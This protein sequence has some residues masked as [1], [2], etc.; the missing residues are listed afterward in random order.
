LKFIPLG[1]SEAMYLSLGGEIRQDM[2]YFDNAR[3]GQSPQSDPYS[4]QRYMLASDWHLGPRFRLYFQIKSGLE[5]G[6]KGGPRQMIDEDKLDVNNG[7]ADIQLLSKGDT[8]IVFRL[9][10]QELAFG[11]RRY[12]SARDGPNVRQTFDGFRLNLLTRG[13]DVSAFA[14]RPVSTDPGIFDDG[15]LQGHSFWGVYAAHPKLVLR[16]NIDI[17]YFGYQRNPATF[18]R[19]TAAESRQSLGARAWS[20]KRAWDYDIE[21]ILQFGTFGDSNILAWAT[22][23]EVGHTLSQTALTPRLAVRSSISSGDKPSKDSSLG[24]FNPLFPRGQYHQLVNLNGHVNLIDFDPLISINP[25]PKMTITTDCDVFWRE[26]LGDG[27]YTVGGSP[28]KASGNS[29][30]R[31]I[32]TQPNVIMV[33]P[34]QRHFTAVFI[35]SHFFS[36]AYLHQAPTFTT[37][38]GIV[39][40]YYRSVNYVSTWLDFRF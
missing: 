19:G 24:T 30:A 5:F 40:P 38:E 6:R 12:V 17:Y 37:T 18:N 20:G 23:A 21:S 25:V 14:T 36:S 15:D 7:F 2:E 8:Q 10:R 4:L 22:E 29:P 3:W 27:I 9:G 34:L 35:Y 11:S 13:W 32:G 33:W 39:G 1:G 31:Y 16:S 26:S 28:L